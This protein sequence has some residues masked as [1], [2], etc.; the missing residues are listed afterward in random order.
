[1]TLKYK[2]VAKDLAQKIEDQVYTTKLPSEQ[3]LI[4][5]YQVSRNT[6]RNALNLLYNQGMVRSIQGSGYFVNTPSKNDN[7]IING[8]SKKGLYDLEK[9]DP[10]VSK[11]L[12][13]KIIQAD[14]EIADKLQCQEGADI[15][16]VKRLRSNS[17]EV[18][19]LE[20]AYYLKSIVPYLT[21]EI[22]RESIFN[23][24][25]KTYNLEIKNGD[26]FIKLHYLSKSEAEITNSREHTAALHVTEINYLKNE[27]PFNYSK[28]L[29]LQSDLTLYYH[30]SN[31][32]D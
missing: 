14:K 28:T 1:M 5:N 8:G 20:D 12:E 16:H 6:I 3:E 25:T 26:E 15:Y 11:V 4:A 30:V 10:I 31:Y 22:C 13:L 7:N 9:K 23:F 21:E 18:V 29:Y 24:I 27:Q 19:S 2:V 32:L 17:K